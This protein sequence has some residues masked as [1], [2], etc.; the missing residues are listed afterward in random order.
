MLLTNKG[1]YQV[2]VVSYVASGC[3]ARNAANVYTSTSGYIE[4][5]KAAIDALV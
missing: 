1:V 4:W 5:I 2:G 3:D